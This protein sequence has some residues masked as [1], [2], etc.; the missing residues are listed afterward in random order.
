MKTKAVLAKSADIIAFVHQ[1]CGT[2]NTRAF[3][4]QMRSIKH[5]FLRL[6]NVGAHQWRRILEKMTLN[7]MTKI[8]LILYVYKI[9]KD[10]FEVSPSSD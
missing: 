7:C 9:A 8:K 6:P 1:Y 5:N 3:S 4:C 2:H 10:N